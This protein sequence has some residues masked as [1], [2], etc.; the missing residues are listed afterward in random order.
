MILSSTLSL[1]NTLASCGRYPDAHLG[2][3]VHGKFGDVEVVQENI[4]LVGLY[5]SHYLVKRCCFPCAVRTEQP[6]I[7]WLTVKLYFIHCSTASVDLNEVLCF[8][9]EVQVILL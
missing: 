2:S 1:R 3:F 7:S 4:S 8:N 5:Q 9:G 6:T